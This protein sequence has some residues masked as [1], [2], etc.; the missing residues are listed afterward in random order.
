MK[1][2][3]FVAGQEKDADEGVTKLTF[4]LE[5]DESGDLEL[6]GGG[7]EGSDFC[8]AFISCRD[9]QLYKIG[10]LP[11]RLGLRLNR[12]GEIKTAK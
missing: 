9:G 2:Q 12:A 7:G 1:R 10:G 8:V 3:F 6:W 11:E 4:R 5:V